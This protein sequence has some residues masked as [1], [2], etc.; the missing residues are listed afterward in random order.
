MAEKITFDSV[1]ET[2]AEMRAELSELRRLLS[3]REEAHKYT[4]KLMVIEEAADFL[5]LSKATLYRLVSNRSIPFHKQSGKL[6]FL[7]KE[8]LEWIKAGRKLGGM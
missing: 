7:E 3:N 1:P 8:L 6:Y 5:N 2:L 4:N